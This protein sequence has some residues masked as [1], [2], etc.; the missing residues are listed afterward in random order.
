MIIK[1]FDNVLWK[2]ILRLIIIFSPFSVH[3]KSAYLNKGQKIDIAVSF[4]TM[5]LG[6]AHGILNA[7][8]ETGNL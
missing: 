2:L 5:H 4:K 1:C 7:L 8:F 3:P 6:E